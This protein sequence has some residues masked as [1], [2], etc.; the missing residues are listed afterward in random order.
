MDLIGGN[1][2]VSLTAICALFKVAQT[3][4]AGTALV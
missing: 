3:V 2:V 1:I 4:S